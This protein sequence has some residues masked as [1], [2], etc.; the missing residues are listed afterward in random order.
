[1]IELVLGGIFF[2]IVAI[3]IKCI[4]SHHPRRLRWSRLQRLFY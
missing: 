1:M 4:N 3:S 2:F